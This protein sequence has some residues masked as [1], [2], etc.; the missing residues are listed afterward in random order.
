MPVSHGGWQLT[1]GKDMLTSTITLS[2]NS[3]NKVLARVNDSEPYSSTYFLEDGDD[4]YTLNIKHT[5]PAS[6]GASKES[7]L[8][9][10]DV[11]NYDG[12]T[13]EILHKQSVWTVMEASTGKQDSTTLGY[14]S[15]GLLTWVST[16][17]ALILARDS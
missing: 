7:H 10:L 15:A 17:K 12:T 5:V 11:V 13:G 4:D 2:I 3:V 6:R 16:N 8:V 9:R 14:Y 1:Q